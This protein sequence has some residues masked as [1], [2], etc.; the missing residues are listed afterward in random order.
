MDYSTF[1]KADK[2]LLIAPAGYGKTYTLVETIKHTEG[3]QL[4]LT[5][6][7]AGLAS[8]KSK[9]KEA[10][11]S[12]SKFCVD[13]ISSFC[14]KYCIAFCNKTKLPQRKIGKG[15]KDNYFKELLVHMK[16]VVSSPLVEKVIRAS[17]KGLLVDEYQDCTMS[18]HEIIMILSNYLPTRIFGDPLQGIYALG[19]EL[20]CFERDLSMFTKFQELTTPHRWYKEGNNAE[21]GN[22]IKSYREPLQNGQPINVVH[23]PNINHY[24]I[25][26]NDKELWDDNEYYLD[27]LRGLVRNENNIESFENLLIIVPEYIEKK[28]EKRKRGGISDR[29]K[30]LSHI[31]F[32]NSVIPLEAIDD[33][34][35]YSVAQSIDNLIA[36]PQ[37]PIKKIHSLLGQ[38]YLK[39]GNNHTGL[40]NWFVESKHPQD[41]G[42][43]NKRGG[44]KL[45]SES[46][47][48][49][50]DRFIETPQPSSLL[51]IIE[52]VNNELKLKKNKRVELRNA[53]IKCLKDSAVSGDSVF[54]CMENHKNTIR[55]LGRKTDAKCI[56][57]TLL[58]KGLEYD[59]VAIM[60]A[61][62]FS[63]PKHLYVAL[64]RCSK[65][66]VIF[67]AS[68]R[69]FPHPQ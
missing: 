54:K 38:M 67:T 31:D 26:I 69:L 49:A 37:K 23:N 1:A 7:H 59:T 45:K 35:F 14:Q 17:Y 56:G 61:H 48:K 4:I 27:K 51:A 53:V 34:T 46:L 36:S 40:K 39:T 2:G 50:L 3:K 66:L 42:V 21:L 32:S 8:I 6:T 29:L 62:K 68:N 63:C 30:V 52:F 13:T 64:T 60:D 41:Y 11:I 25:K 47:R 57:T 5:H 55:R 22:V 20:V 12:S 43:V 19:E 16:E 18:Q 44:L 28:K 65:N 58:T 33:H 15:V 24:V 10:E 9:L